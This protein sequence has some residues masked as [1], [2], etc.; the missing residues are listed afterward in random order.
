M[1]NNDSKPSANDI[2]LSQTSGT[3]ANT[4]VIRNPKVVKRIRPH[5]ISPYQ[6]YVSLLPEEFRRL[7]TSRIA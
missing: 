5:V 2:S 3:T 7:T 1:E 4:V 6:H